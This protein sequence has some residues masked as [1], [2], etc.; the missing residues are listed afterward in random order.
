MQEILK[1]VESAKEILPSDFVDN[2][3][4]SVENLL[5]VET[6][7]AIC[8]K[9]KLHLTE[10]NIQHQKTLECLQEKIKLEQH[11]YDE[12]KQ[13]RHTSIMSKTKYSIRKFFIL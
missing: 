8:E 3:N 5:T 6:R 9:E 7:V 1:A 13:N 2:F 10:T 11:Q 12:D 4:N